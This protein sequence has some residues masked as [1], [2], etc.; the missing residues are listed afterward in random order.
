MNFLAHAYLSFDHPKILVG[1]MISDFVKGKTKFSFSEEIQKG[2][3]LH[4]A[5]DS[6]T[7]NHEATKKAKEIFRP[8]YRLYSGAIMDILYDHFLANDKKIFSETSLKLFTTAVYSVLEEHASELPPHFVYILPY[9]KTEDWLFGYQYKE[10]IKKS[11]KGLIRRATYISESDTAYQLF[12]ENYSILEECYA[13]FFPDVK[14][15][16]KEKF[17]KLVVS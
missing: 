16:A 12:L 10:G 17:D 4:R 15:F 8:A 9:M 6:F 2:I 1:N 11:L 14:Q 3:E 7:D 13:I 5:I